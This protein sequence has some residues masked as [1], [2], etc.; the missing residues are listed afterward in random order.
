MPVSAE[1]S[2]IAAITALAA[3][4]DRLVREL[5]LSDAFC[6]LAGI[7]REQRLSFAG[8]P[9]LDAL[10]LFDQ[11]RGAWINPRGRRIRDQTTGEIWSVLASGAD[12][13]PQVSL[14][15]G[16]RRF[17]LPM[18]F[19][20]H[21][22][23]AA[24]VAGLRA[25]AT[26]AELFEDELAEWATKLEAGPLSNSELDKLD[27]LLA[28]APAR[29][30]AQVGAEFRKTTIDLR[31]LVP[32][33]PLYYERLIGKLRSSGDVEGFLATEARELM[34]RV[35]AQVSEVALR[36]ALLLCAHP[37]TSQIIAETLGPDRVEP[38]VPSDL[39][40]QIG[41]VEYLAR[42]PSPDQRELARATE[43]L[44]G[45][46][47][48]DGFAL[49][50]LNVT[51]AFVDGEIAKLGILAQEPPFWRR[52]AALAHAALLCRTMPPQLRV[53]AK[54][55]EQLH[56][57]GRYAFAI[58]TMLDLQREPR[59]V[60]RYASKEQW[61]AELVGR[62]LGAIIP[63]A[64][65]KGAQDELAT[66][67]SSLRELF[68]DYT[69][70][71]AFLPGPCEGAGQAPLAPEAE[72]RD[73]IL[74]ALQQRP[75]GPDAF[76]RLIGMG[77]MFRVDRELVD[78]AVAAL[79]DLI[80]EAALG[81]PNRE[82][83]QLLPHLAH[84]A[85]VT[86]DAELATQVRVLCRV[87]RRQTPPHLDTLTEFEVCLLA[88]AAHE[89]V[90]SYRRELASWLEELTYGA[91]SR[92]A[93][94]NLELHLQFMAYRDPDLWP[95]LAPALSLAEGRSLAAIADAPNP[96]GSQI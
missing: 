16:K 53:N 2:R 93:T 32:P 85:G 21:P 54:F 41:Y 91:A 65:A 86:R 7:Q 35:D 56:D 5:P 73:G 88:C 18:A 12:A 6:A 62:A 63:H 30:E 55:R 15:R 96:Q 67:C 46:L 3:L 92:G 33:S 75:V 51:F 9:S 48:E 26:E 34:Q 81:G 38:Q 36:R 19:A 70:A 37:R 22:N 83:E 66:A 49:D 61:K 40:S 47:G 90:Q 77:L 72:G 95:H 60:P 39:L 28:T 45:S 31:A 20:L 43:A 87:A 57:V 11:V 23:G 84:L 58:A 82:V 10:H 1:Q 59:W 94:I 44:R 64:E 74:H 24:R 4:P 13:E 69:A 89:D 50:L 78:A 14:I 27:D 42:A 80:Q 71:A 25:A 29:V 76:L 8:G 52:M 17:K 79:R 68:V